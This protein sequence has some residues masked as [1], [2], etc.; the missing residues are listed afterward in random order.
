M[1]EG[2]TV[3]RACRQL[4]E[5]LAGKVLTR[6][7]LRVPRHATA[8][9]IG[10]TV[11]EVRPRGKHLLIRLEA[12]EG[13]GADAL[14]LHSHLMMEGIWQIDGELMRGSDLSG[15]RRAMHTARIVLEAAPPDASPD[16]PVTRA[17]GFEVQ[18]VRL[19]PRRS[20]SEL[21]GHL[22]PD[23]LDPDWSTE[24]RDEAARNLM[25]DPDRPIGNAL[26][27]QRL[28]AGVGNVYRSELCFMRRLHPAAPAQELDDPAGMVDLAQRLLELNKDRTTRITTGG[29]LGRDGDLWVY[30]RAGRQ[31][32]RCRTRLQRGELAEPGIEGSEPRVIVTCPRCQGP[33]PRA[34]RIPSRAR[35]H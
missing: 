35:N 12:P 17:I 6:A 16:D 21:V 5:A 8:D 27:D 24:L 10:W 34:T 3:W 33:G 26:L 28:L 13:T 20:E 31:C 19:L 1:P 11:T 14:T 18:Q 30:G 15:T 29:M 32:R 23:L 25:A 4:D 9:L 2:D 7:E 22:G